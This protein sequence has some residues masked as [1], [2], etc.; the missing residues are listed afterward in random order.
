MISD[1]LQSKII[2]TLASGKALAAL[3]L[4]EIINK[5]GYEYTHQAIYKELK[6]LQS[7]GVVIKV[8]KKIQLHLSWLLD[9][10]QKLQAAFQNVLKYSSLK[11]ILP[12]SQ[13]K[14]IWTF[15]NLLTMDDF[16]SQLLIILANQSQSKNIYEWSPHTWYELLH[17][18][19]ETKFQKALRLNQQKI[20]LIVGSDSYLDQSCAKFWPEDIYK[21][22]F[23]E[24]P[25]HEKR[26]LYFNIIDDYILEIKY[27]S[28]LALEIDDYYNYVTNKNK[29]KA[30]EYI[31]LINK[32]RPVKLSL[33]RN[34]H[35]AT[36]I[37]KLFI[38]F[39]GISL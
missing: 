34:P 2:S 16:W 17:R 31:S 4:Q 6:K 3:E 32:R 29:F 39:F 28:N 18:E 38:N 22:S 14:R 8:N 35:K 27:P 20:Y 11:E 21:H 5:Q 10:Q 15:N 1:N 7:A 26:S 24:G 23:A 13:K 33:E 19:K 25:F 36:R 37:T 9:E 12:Q 30:G